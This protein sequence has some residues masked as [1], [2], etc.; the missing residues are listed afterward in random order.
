MGLQ[1][2]HLHLWANG[3]VFDRDG[4]QLMGA[5]VDPGIQLTEARAQLVNCFGL[6]LGR[7]GWLARP[8]LMP[9]VGL[10]AGIFR[11]P[12]RQQQRHQ[13]GSWLEHA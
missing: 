5:H 8:K 11:Q 9:V 2:V 4:H 13:R 6:L 12:Q 3:S 1:H 7:L 10:S